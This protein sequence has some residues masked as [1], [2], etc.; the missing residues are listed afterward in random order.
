M[1]DWSVAM[2]A[3]RAPV[4]TSIASELCFLVDCPRCFGNYDWSEWRR[5]RLLCQYCVMEVDRESFA[6]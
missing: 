5:D 1:I 4:M 2:E 6:N 3:H